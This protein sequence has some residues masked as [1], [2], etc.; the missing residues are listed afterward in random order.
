MKTVARSCLFCLAMWAASA[1]AEEPVV[2]AVDAAA[3]NIHWRVY[4]AGTFSRF[5]HNHVVSVGQISGEVTRDA[6]SGA[7]T[8]ELTIPVAGLVVDDPTLRSLY[9]EDF[10]SKPSEDDIAGTRKNMLGDK[11]LDAEKYPTLAV[12]GRIEGGAPEAATLAVTV[13]LQGRTVPVSVPC[14]IAIEDD[15][16]TASGEFRLTHA[17]LGMEPFS[18]MMGAL[19][20]APELD[21]SFDVHAMR[22]H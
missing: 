22:V 15:V 11:V 19:A 2:Y 9:G 1:V 17:E 7:G 3:S 10:S 18:V 13:E 4:K 16:L 21:F 6:G 8:F 20:V 12:H 14:K 5:G